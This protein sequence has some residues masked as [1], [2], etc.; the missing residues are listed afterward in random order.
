MSNT[1][2]NLFSFTG[3]MK[4]L[5]M[6]WLAFFIS[7]A[8]WFN[9]APLMLVIA[10]SL[11]LSQA[12]VKTILILN[13]ALT[14]P[15]RIL[16]GIL[17]DKFGPKR[18]Y[19][20]LLAL[21]SLPCF[22]FAVADDFEQL[23]L[24]RFL[25]GFVGAGFVIGIRMVGEWFPARQVGIAEGIY[26]GWGNFGSAAAAIVLPSEAKTDGAMPSAVPV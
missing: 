3:K 14:I 9:H 22:L 21:G 24:A 16:I 10:E 7:F 11:S 25:M 13:V 17:V 12:E 4:I 5:H 1:L 26:G 19:S 23:A 15:S 20:T 2:L 8:V 18:T 6:T